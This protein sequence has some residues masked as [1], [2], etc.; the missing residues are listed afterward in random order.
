MSV[1]EDNDITDYQHKA[2]KIRVPE[3]FERFDYVLGMDQ[4]NIMDMRDFIKRAAKKGSLDAKEASK[5]VHMYGEFGGKT[6]GEE[7]VDPYYGGR[8]GFTIAYEQMTRFGKGLLKDIEQQAAREL[9]ST[10]P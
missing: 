3:D 8:D 7:V 1:L 4:E 2:R 10:A 5:K 9:G 6:K